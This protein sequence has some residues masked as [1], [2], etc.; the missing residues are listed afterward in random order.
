VD[1]V[2]YKIGDKILYGSVGIMEI[3]D[4]AH[5]KFAGFD[6]S[7]YVLRELFVSGDSKTYVPFDNARLLSQMH[8][9]LS[10]KELSSILESAKDVKPGAFEENNR[11]RMEKYR[12]LMESGDR[13]AI[14]SI[15][16]SIDEMAISRAAFGKK[17]YISD[18]TA[19]KRA[20]RLLS[21]EASLVFGI[22]EIEAEALI[23]DK[24]SA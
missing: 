8:P 17:N 13:L 22:S 10:K 16:K 7:Y 6:K 20:M 4:V 1:F 5:E 11:T 9:L 14:V 18:Q 21:L 15:I 19:K 3:I 24:I 12:A 2:N 23:K